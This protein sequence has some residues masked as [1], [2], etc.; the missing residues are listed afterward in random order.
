VPN[1]TGKNTNNQI[2]SKLQ[3]PNTKQ[4]IN[5]KKI[6]KLGKERKTRKVENSRTAI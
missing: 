1:A 5:S 4:R 2:K 3:N 6:H